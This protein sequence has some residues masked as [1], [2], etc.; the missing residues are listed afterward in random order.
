M[1]R[2]LESPRSI[3]PGPILARRLRG[4]QEE[5]EQATLSRISRIVT[6][7]EFDDGTYS[8]GLQR[9]VRAALMYGYDLVESP[10]EKTDLAPVALLTAA[11]TAARK[12]IP[13]DIILRGYLAGQALLADYIADEAG[14]DGSVQGPELHNVLR[15]LPRCAGRLLDEVSTE[16]T[17]ERQRSVT[18]VHDRL[19]ARVDRLLSATSLDTSGINY[20]FSLVHT[21]VVAVGAGAAKLLRAVAAT[22]GHRFLQVTEEQGGVSAWLG[23][24]RPLRPND[25]DG[26]RSIDSSTNIRLALGEATSGLDG[27]RLTHLQAKLALPF[28]LR[29]QSGLVRYMDVALPATMLRDKVL[30]DSVRRRYLARLDSEQ[31]GGEVSR[32][33]LRAY[34]AANRNISSAAAALGV[35]RHTV[36]RRIRSLEQRLGCSLNNCEGEV[37]AAL[38]VE[39]IKMEQAT[40]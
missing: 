21:G 27:W 19:A 39:K 40:L 1:S 22:G 38:Q 32:E 17:Q 4:R 12:D 9:V 15:S 26:L 8:H 23:S 16:Y 14:R 28:A 34:W 36:T 10:A 5:I 24:S 30:F 25:L 29:T 31:D 20:D 2:K 13:L 3:D 37:A 11:R 35:N 7:K 6:G 18:S 33:T